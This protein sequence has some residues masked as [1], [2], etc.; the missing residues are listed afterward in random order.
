M[1]GSAL[2]NLPAH[3]AV[4]CHDAGAANIVFAWLRALAR[5]EPELARHWRILAQGPAAQLW[6]EQPVRG[7]RLCGDLEDVLQ[8]VAAL[9]SGTG[10]A[11]HLEHDARA[12]ARARGI[13]SLAVIDHWVNFG[14][15]FVR[16]GHQVLPDRILVTDEHALAEAQRC[17]PRLSIEQCANSYLEEVVSAI[18][19]LDERVHD[20]LYVAGPVRAA[21]A[22]ERDRE[23]RSLDFLSAHLGRV[24]DGAPCVL[25]LR[26][27]PSD[28]SAAYDA[29][30][31]DHRELPARLDGSATLAEAIGGARWVAGTESYAMVVAL[32]AGRRVVCALP[33]PFP[34]CRLPHREIVHLRDL[35]APARESAA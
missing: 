19:P 35:V 23:I 30:L 15:R 11:S 17:F 13:A 33:P 18:R 12:A 25:R 20:V 22:G 32:A 7:A 24:A 29:W 2:P 10:W 14:E 4:V 1:R 26:P 9:V 6:A 5:A 27:H 31:A 34:R 3:L 8:G 21:R 28:G 16:D